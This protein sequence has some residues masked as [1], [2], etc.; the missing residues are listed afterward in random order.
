VNK[1]KIYIIYIEK[2]DNKKKNVNIIIS[3]YKIIYKN[4]TKIK[5]NIIYIIIINRWNKNILLK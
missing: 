1:K 5:K 4:T 2:I 3:I